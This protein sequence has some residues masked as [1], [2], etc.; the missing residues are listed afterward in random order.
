MSDDTLQIEIPELTPLGIRN[1]LVP[2]FRPEV[3]GDL[4]AVYQFEV[5]GEPS[6]HL[7]LAEGDFHIGSGAHPSPTLRYF[8][9]DLQATFALLGGQGDWMAEFMAGRIRTDGNLILG[10]H[11]TL[12]FQRR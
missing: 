2:H 9:D 3:C 6:F 4:S 5:A 12:I 1:H 11:L 7:M 10:L 8:F